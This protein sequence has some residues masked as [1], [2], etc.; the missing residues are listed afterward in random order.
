MLYNLRPKVKL[1]TDEKK[2]RY[3][4]KL[5]MD[6]IEFLTIIVSIPL[7]YYITSLFLGFFNYTWQPD[8]QQFT[9]FS[10]FI[11]ISWIVLYQAISM[12]RLPASQRHLTIFFHFVRVN[13]VNLIVLLILKFIFNLQSIPYIFVFFF[14]PISMIIT[15]L[16]RVLAF[17]KLKIYRTNGHNLRRVLVFA[18]YCSESIIDRFIYQKEWGYKV[19]YIVTQ[20]STIKEKYRNDIKILPGFVDIKEV[21]DNQIIDEVIYSKSQ[22]DREELK[23]I[24]RLCNEVGVIFRLQSCTSPVDQVYLQMKT[25]NNQ[26]QLALVDLP[27]NN[28]PL[29]IKGMADIYF[30]LTAVILLSPLFLLTA[31]LIKLESRGP[32]FFKQERVGLRGRKFKLYKFRTMTENA[33][34][35][36]DTLKQENEMDGPAFKMKED[37][38]V[39]RLGK[40][41]RKTGLDE[42]PQLFNVIAGEMSL[43][44]PRPPLEDEVRHYKRW[45][46]RRLS[47]KPGITCTWQVIPNRN[48]V[49][50]EKW[51]QLDLNYIDNW[52]L[53]KDVKLIFK[54]IGAMFMASG[55]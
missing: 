10:I 48:D 41:L 42:F 13:F 20:S 51:M 49:K 18:D 31:L 47:V 43:I 9:F 29:V 27:S 46:L 12:A 52:T 26:K 30:S 33:E 28:I 24:V 50:F 6:V 15:F 7:A 37:P 54:T 55:R 25:L 23:K 38:R 34:E 39:T 2:I 35:L 32:V 1:S 11:L 5:L 53:T 40:I 19:D 36:L 45:H 16:I 21:L 8:L 4:I 3:R 14:V 17:S 22:I 44:G